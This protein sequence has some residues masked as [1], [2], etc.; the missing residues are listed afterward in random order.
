MNLVIL[1]GICILIRLLLAYFISNLKGE[2]LKKSS[3]IGFAVA[4][5]FITMNLINRTKGAF[6]QKVWWRKYRIIHASLYLMF[7]LLA[8]NMNKN[9]YV[10]LVID[11]LLGLIFF[12]NHRMK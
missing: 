11:A 5:G 8:L 3:I 10:P 2:N 4:A 6:G 9:S 7:A 1:F 12:I